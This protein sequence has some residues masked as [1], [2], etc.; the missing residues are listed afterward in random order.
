MSSSL[1]KY[2]HRLL[3]APPTKRAEVGDS[4]RPASGLFVQDGRFTTK[5]QNVASM[6]QIDCCCAT[7]SLQDLD[8]EHRF[9]VSL[10][11]VVV[12]V[13]VAFT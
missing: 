5:I 2:L 6:Y 1:I 12:W 7:L 4:E 3:T 11:V 10:K 13:Y 8:T 9:H